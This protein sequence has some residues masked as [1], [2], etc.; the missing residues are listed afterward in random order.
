[1]PAEVTDGSTADV[2]FHNARRV[3]LSAEIDAEVG[4]LIFPG[5]AGILCGVREVVE[6]LN[7]VDFTGGFWS[8]PEGT[9][10]EAKQPSAVIRGRYSNFGLYE[11]AI[12]GILSSCTG[13]ATA[14]RRIVNSAG[15]I[16]ITSYGARHA[17]PNIAGALDYSAIVGGCIGCSTPLGA[18]LTGTT[19]S[20]T[21]PHALVLLAGDT[22][23]VAK[24]FDEEMPSDVPRIVLVDTFQDEVV[25]SLRVAGALQSH[26]DG[27]RLDTPRE[28]GG[29]TP[30]LVIEC[31]FHLDRIGAEHVKIFV[32]GGVTP[33]RVEQFVQRGAPVDGFGVGSYI[34]G[35][36]PV[37][38]TADIREV[39][40][41]PVAKRGRLPGIP[42]G[43]EERLQ[44]F[45]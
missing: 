29:V 24:L 15:G 35:A 21:M 26:L 28:R 6:L 25:E 3:A 34:A 40:G 12:L 1:M 2:Y 41:Q 16:P 45:I 39:S 9:S 44:R 33:Q 11:T 27:I 43:V 14:A 10:I 30:E 13:W 8:Y 20:G 7:A 36:G 4:M 31:R 18:A 23:R 19:A 38:F 17:H 22:V 37:E 42:S 5:E 32:S